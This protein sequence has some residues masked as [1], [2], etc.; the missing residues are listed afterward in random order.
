MVRLIW[1][2]KYRFQKFIVSFSC[3]GFAGGTLSRQRLPILEP[4][5]IP[6]MKKLFG[7]ENFVNETVTYY[8][9]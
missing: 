6:L 9:F 5:H 7:G 2:T 3:C 4:Q 8:Q 1:N